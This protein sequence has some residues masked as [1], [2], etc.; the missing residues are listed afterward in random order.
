MEFL[1]QLVIL[2]DY[3]IRPQNALGSSPKAGNGEVKS[4]LRKP[5]QFEAVAWRMAVPGRNQVRPHYRRRDPAV[6]T[7][8]SK[9][10][11]SRGGRKLCR[12]ECAQGF[13][14]EGDTGS[15]EENV[16][17]QKLDQLAS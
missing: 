5:Q 1:F 3:S 16:S 13:S 10:K 17:K 4:R 15:R 6:R 12:H 7:T 14:S 2:F 11:K 9:S 8:R